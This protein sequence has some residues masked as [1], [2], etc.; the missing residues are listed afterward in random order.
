MQSALFS[1]LVLGSIAAIVVGG[2][3]AFFAVRSAPEGFE[4]ETGFHALPTNKSN[5]ESRYS[6]S[7]ELEM[8]A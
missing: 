3:I 6:G 7:D 2:I 4:N 1:M 5:K 8:L